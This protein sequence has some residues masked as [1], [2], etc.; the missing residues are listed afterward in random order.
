MALYLIEKSNGIRRWTGGYQAPWH[1]EAQ[2]EED[3]VAIGRSRYPSKNGVDQFH[4]RLVTEEDLKNLA[5][6]AIR[7]AALKRPTVTPAQLR[8]AAYLDRLRR[9]KLAAL[10]GNVQRVGLTPGIQRIAEKI[11]ADAEA[12]IER[13][14]R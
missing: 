6:G 3:A 1:V 2:S 10:D 4:A 9:N 11:D 14:M 8:L 5:E 7:H 13:A 12:T